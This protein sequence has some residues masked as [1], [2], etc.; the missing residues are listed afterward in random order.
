VTDDGALAVLLDTS[1][2]KK[3]ENEP[4]YYDTFYFQYK[5]LLML[6]LPK[7]ARESLANKAQS[8]F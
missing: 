7:K 8:F 3:N 5:W 4:H 2:F 1:S 6:A